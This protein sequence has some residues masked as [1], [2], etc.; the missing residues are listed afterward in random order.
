[1]SV[2]EI[3]KR[4]NGQALRIR[5]LSSLT[6]DGPSEVVGWTSSSLASGAS[7]TFSG[8]PGAGQTQRKAFYISNL[9]PNS[10]LDILDD[11]DNF[12]L[13]IFPETSIVLPTS[14]SLKVKNNS[15]ASITLY[16]SEIFYT[17]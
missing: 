6:A 7:Q 2:K 13:A 14:G 4:N 8:T 10:R 12:A 17:S 15:G 11:D 9:D 5:G 3:V 1:M 16:V